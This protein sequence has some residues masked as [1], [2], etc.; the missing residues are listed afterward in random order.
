MRILVVGNGAREHALLWKLRQ[1]APDAELF[2]TRGN[3]GTPSL[4]TSRPLDPADAPA[5]AAWARSQ[6]VQLVVVGPETPPADWRG[7]NAGTP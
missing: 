1:D 3:G 5:L 6:G 7:P 4:A 2:V